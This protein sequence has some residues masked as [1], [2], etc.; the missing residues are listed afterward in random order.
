MRG[1]ILRNLR[2]TSNHFLKS[3]VSFEWTARNEL[4]MTHNIL[5]AEPSDD[6][7][8]SIVNGLRRQ[9]PKAQILRVKDGEQAVRFLFQRGLLTEEP[10]TPDLVVLAAELPRLPTNAVIARLRQDPRT[11]SIPIV[12]VYPDTDPDERSGTRRWLHRRPDIIVITGTHRLDKE[13]A[14]AMSQ[15]GTN[16]SAATE[17][18]VMGTS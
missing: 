9:R 5:V 16:R 2:R 7:W 6:T 11:L 13:V 8:A 10:E 17:Q 3:L 1:K 18:G 4:R 12:L 14:N 15:L